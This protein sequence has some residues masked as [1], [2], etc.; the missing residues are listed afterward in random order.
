MAQNTRILKLHKYNT[1]KSYRT[2][3]HGKNPQTDSQT[4]D[5]KNAQRKNLYSIKIRPDPLTS[6]TISSET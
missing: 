2:M 3:I 1:Q 5:Y 4:Y 6:E